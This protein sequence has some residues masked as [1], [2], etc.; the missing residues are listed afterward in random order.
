MFT[1]GTWILFH[2]RPPPKQVEILFLSIKKKG[3]EKTQ[4]QK[5]PNQILQANRRN[6]AWLMAH[7]AQKSRKLQHPRSGIPRTAFLEGAPSL[8]LPVPPAKPSRFSPPGCG[9]S[10]WDP[11]SAPAW[12]RYRASRRP[13][14]RLSLQSPCKRSPAAVLCSPPLRTQDLALCQ[15]IP[16][17]KRGN[18]VLHQQPAGCCAHLETLTQRLNTQN[19]GTIV[20]LEKTGK[21]AQP[22]REE[23]ERP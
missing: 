11:R 20:T 22:H 23:L 15:A 8:S 13:T 10:S 3:K 18:S 19:P 21:Q 4:K 12:L 9:S 1:E 17:G 14:A 5:A 16:G 6:P 7:K 2:W